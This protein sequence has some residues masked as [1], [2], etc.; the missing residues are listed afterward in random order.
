MENIG[1][2]ASNLDKLYPGTHAVNDVSLHVQPGEVVA[3]LGENGAGKSTLAKLIAGVELPTS[4]KMI[5]EGRAYAPASPFAAQMAGIGMIHQ[6]LQLFPDLTAMENVL[7]GHLPVSKFGWISRKE[8]HRRATAALDRIGFA[9]NP[10]SLVSSLSVAAQQQVEIAR[11]L[12][13][14]ARLLLLDEPT[15]A[16]GAEETQKLFECIRLLKTDGVSFI[17]VSHRLDEIAQIA[18]RIVVMRDGRFVAAHD[19]G[20]KDKNQLIAEMVGRSVDRL[21]PVFAEPCEE[22]VLRVK[23]LTGKRFQNISFEVRAGEVL[24]IAGIVGA[25]RTELIRAVMGVDRYTSGS[26]ELLGESLSPGTVRDSIRA[27]MVMI[28]EDRKRQGVIVPMTIQDNI[29]ISNL[30]RLGKSGF[31]GKTGFIGTREVTKYAHHIVERYG[32]KGKPQDAVR[33]LSGGNQQKVVL[34]KWLI[35]EPKLVFLDEPTRGIDVGARAAIY[36]L[37]AEL[38]K[39]GVAIVLVSSDLEEVLG[40]SHRVLVLA[41]GENRGVLPREDATPEKVMTLA[42]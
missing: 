15:S 28:P 12:A 13:S 41:K 20:K 2:I 10:N 19:T 17:Y 5:W 7:A 34:G 16:L 8:L 18:D 25:G 42:L 26:V 36:G 40:L 1:L 27:E 14:E 38:S 29:A 6:E 35:R 23:S 21:Y 24:G 39:N 31:F 3:L 32:I 9:P 33:S 37:I 22:P 11:A 30:D 4:G